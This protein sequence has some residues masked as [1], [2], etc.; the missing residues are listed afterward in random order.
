[1]RLNIF[2]VLFLLLF[3]MSSIA[4][5]RRDS[6]LGDFI[7]VEATVS[8]IKDLETTQTIEIV[9]YGPKELVTSTFKDFNSKSGKRTRH[10]PSPPL[11]VGQKGLWIL[12]RV[13]GNLQL[14]HLRPFENQNRIRLN[15]SRRY[16]EYSSLATEI[17]RISAAPPQERLV[18]IKALAQSRV[19]E[20]AQWSIYATPEIAQSQ[21]LSVLKEYSQAGLP[22]VAA[23]LV[24]D[25]TLLNQ[26]DQWETSDARRAL[27]EKVV[28]LG[29]SE[30]EG[31]NLESELS[32]LIKSQKFEA[33]FLKKL[34][35]RAQTNS[36]LS[37]EQLQ[38]YKKLE[39]S[40]EH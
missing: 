1:M 39:K 10:D 37:E 32:S 23:N 31:W 25:R 4:N 11:E 24:L 18:L 27:Y 22:T 40:L 9:Y 21:S 28:Q 20:V 2:H 19:P 30:S 12:K 6:F 13:D 3:T 38:I 35:S 34:I 15:I 17:G 8:S 5:E 7:L 26:D 36:S 33:A 16:T 29:M 14:A